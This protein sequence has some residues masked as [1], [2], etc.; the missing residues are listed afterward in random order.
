[1]PAKRPKYSCLDVSK[2]EKLL[3]RKMMS[4][5][6]GLKTMRKQEPKKR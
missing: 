6:E 1:L 3:G 2:V 4:F 5:E